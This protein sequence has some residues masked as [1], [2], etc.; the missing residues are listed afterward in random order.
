MQLADDDTMV[1][2]S[3]ADLEH[4]SCYKQW[5]A[6]GSVAYNI[7]GKVMLDL[8]VQMVLEKRRV[9]RNVFGT[10]GAPERLSKVLLISS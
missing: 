2:E 5:S 8:L 1:K 3:P 4:T 7:V 9:S 10:G 6:I